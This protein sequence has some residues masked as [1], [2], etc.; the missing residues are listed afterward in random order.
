MN[1][2]LKSTIVA[3]AMI[4]APLAGVSAGALDTIKEAGVLKVAVP[5][6]FPPFGSVGTDMQ[7]KG[8]DIDMAA[9]I[10]SD[11]GVKLE[12]VPVA[13]SNRIPYLTTGK[14]DLVISSLGKNPDREKVI[15][16][17]DPY[18]PFYNGVFGPA[19]IAVK[20]A[21]DLSGHSV[22]VTR[23]AI[24]DLELT[25][26]A[27]ADLEI[28]RYED[29]N[30]TISAFLSGQVDLIATGN[31]TAAAIIE[32]NPPRKP[33]PKFLIK[34]SPCYVGLNKDEDAF[35]AKVNEIIAASIADGR[36]NAIAE[37]WLGIPLPEKL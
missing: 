18:A 37:K 13:S 6:D 5:Q 17:T 29:N 9:L 22:G 10:A 25:K 27:P 23:G 20:G 31:V 4:A 32:R 28:K 2:F 19:D 14:V 26:I 36:L 35:K 16:F 8:Y 7:P 12:L 11:L 24:E 33:E 21:E 1:K 15:D 3:I 30:G 34:N